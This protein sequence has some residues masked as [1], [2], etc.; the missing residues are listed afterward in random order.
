MATTLHGNIQLVVSRILGDGEF[1]AE[2]RRAGIEAVK[3]G[4]GTDA[5][6]K[7]L[8][9]FA[10]TPGELDGLGVKGAAGSCTCDSNTWFI[11]SSIAGP[12]Y[13]CCATTTTTTTSGNFFER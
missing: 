7:Y 6:R 11:F 12:M 8:A 13:T 9:Y 2:V 1:A 4:A 10:S 5:F 3:A